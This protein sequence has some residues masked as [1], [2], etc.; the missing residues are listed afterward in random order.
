MK[1]EGGLLGRREQKGMEEK[2]DWGMNIIKVCYMH[3]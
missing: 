1:V 2:Q 3:T